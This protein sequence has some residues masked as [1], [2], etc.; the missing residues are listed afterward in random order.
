[1]L[2]QTVSESGDLRHVSAPCVATICRNH[3]S[4]QSVANKYCRIK[5]PS[6][7]LDRFLTPGEYNA[8]SAP[9]R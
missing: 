6:F 9:A 8:R 1:M 3:V 2:L 5:A 7:K 4:P